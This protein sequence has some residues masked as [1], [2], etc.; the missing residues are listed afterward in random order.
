MNTPKWQVLLADDHAII[1][2]G[3]KNILAD[4]SDFVVAGEASNGNTAL[5][6]VRQRDWAVVVL[7]IIAHLRKNGV[8][9]VVEQQVKVDSNVMC[10]TPMQQAEVKLQAD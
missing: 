7:D 5:E 10:K 2:N 3:L 1:R 8:V 4:T 9:T 6:M